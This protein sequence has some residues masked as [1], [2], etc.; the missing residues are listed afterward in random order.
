MKLNILLGAL[1]AIVIYFAVFC[2]IRYN[3]RYE[4]RNFAD[5]RITRTVVIVSE[6]YSIVKVALTPLIYLDTKYFDVWWFTD[7]EY[8]IP[9]QGNPLVKKL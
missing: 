3:N 4:I 6:K 1:I 7:S 2:I 9:L 5:T 8:G